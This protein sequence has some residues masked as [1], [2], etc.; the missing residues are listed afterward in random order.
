MLKPKANF[1]I[2][3]FLNKYIPWIIGRYFHRVDFNVPNFKA[4]QS[5]LLIA[6]HF[7]WW[8]GF[9]L[10]HV[11]KLVFK[12]KFHAMVLEESMKEVKIFKYLGGF[13]VSKNSRQM[14]ESLDYAA[15]LL[16]DSGNMVVIFPQGKLYSN[17]V[18][19]LNFEKGASYIARKAKAKFS[20]VFSAA[21]IENFQYKKPTA[22]I[23][24]K[25]FNVD[26]IVPENLHQEYQQHY[27]QSKQQQTTIEV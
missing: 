3:G 23:Y 2:T 9:L 21:F 22:N 16:N 12:K 15:G 10:Y 26:D 20:Y 7:S 18:D 11:N 14:L 19:E 27:H 13:S 1:F 5:I 17:F 24:L 4:G 8:D 6:N 25:V